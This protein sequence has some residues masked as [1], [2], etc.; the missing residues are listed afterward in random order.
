MQA[1]IQLSAVVRAHNPLSDVTYT[2]TVTD[3]SGCTD[4]DSVSITVDLCT[5]I[6]ESTSNTGITINPNP[7]GSNTLIKVKGK[8]PHTL[9]IRV[10]D[11]TGKE[12]E[13]VISIKEGGLQLEKGT[14]SPGL[15]F[16]QLFEGKKHIGASKLLVH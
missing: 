4:Q 11:L 13:C 10:F 14:L 3:A 16:V 15:F 9:T 7:F 2:V 1:P 12:V 5:G 6:E 8:D